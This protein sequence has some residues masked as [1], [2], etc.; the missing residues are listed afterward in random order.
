[1]NST[2]TPDLRSELRNT[3]TQQGFSPEDLIARLMSSGYDQVTAT[4][5][6]M[7]ELKAYRIELFQQTDKPRSGKLARWAVFLAVLLIAAIGPVSGI[8]ALAWYGGAAVLAGLV[9][10]WATSSPKR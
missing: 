7:A 5:L 8:P 2:L 6:L 3:I 9:G 1:M 4:Q 10:Y